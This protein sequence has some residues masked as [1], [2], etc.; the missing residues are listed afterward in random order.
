MGPAQPP[1]MQDF[2]PQG[3][4]MAPNGCWSYSH[5]IHSR[6]MRRALGKERVLSMKAASFKKISQGPTRQLPPSSHRPDY[7][8]MAT[9]S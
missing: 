6:I 1:L 7:K 2:R 9:S 3:N 8:H 4:L 5:L